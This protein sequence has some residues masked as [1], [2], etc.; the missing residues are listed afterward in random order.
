M[1]IAEILKGAPTGT[2]LYSIIHG[3]VTLQSVNFNVG[4]YS[5]SIWV[6]GLGIVSLTES[7]HYLNGIPDSE[8]ILF[9]SKEQR[10]W[11]KFRVDLPEGTPVVIFESVNKPFSSTIRRY[12]GDGKYE[13][14]SGDVNTYPYIVPFNKIKIEDGKFVFDEKNNYGTKGK[15]DEV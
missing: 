10:D 12:A 3:K 15:E 14:L 2:K 13:M 5:I 11:T 9:P 4:L 7:G 6:N 8:P 1:N